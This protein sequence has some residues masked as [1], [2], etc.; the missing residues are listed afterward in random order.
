MAESRALAIRST[1]YLGSVPRIGGAEWRLHGQDGGLSIDL[2]D[3]SLFVFSDTLLTSNPG[4]DPR[5][6][7]FIP[8]QTGMQGYFLANCAG[9]A[10]GT[11]GGLRQ[12]LGRLRYFEDAR[13]W[14]REILAAT[15]EERRLGLRFWP[16]HG[17]TIDGVV[18]IFYLGILCTEPGKTWGFRC[19][20]TGLARLDP[21]SGKC[22]RLSWRDGWCFWPVLGDDFHVGVQ[23]LRDG[24][25]LYV[26]ATLRDWLDNSLRLLRVRPEAIADPD[27]YQVLASTRPRWSR[28][29]ADACDLSPCASECSVS[30][31]A[32]L[33]RYLLS[34]IHPFDKVLILRTS[35]HPWGPYSPPQ[36]IA[37]VPHLAASDLVFLTFEHPQFA[38]AGGR[39]LHLSYSQPSFAPNALLVVTLE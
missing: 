10:A 5:W 31:N 12:A 30:R 8:N 20:G 35:E 26:F 3:E 24:D 28:R 15:A 25:W 37:R 14:P 4:S 22:E 19:L 36:I 29:L 11:R 23:V 32:F 27:R 38:A 9:L 33:G 6:S 34:Y 2:G 1:R 17:V 7:S 21:A 13:G 39:E 18:Y 16:Q